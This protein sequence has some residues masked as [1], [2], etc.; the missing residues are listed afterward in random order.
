MAGAAPSEFYWVAADNVQVP[1]TL[2]DLKG[3][4]LAMLARGCAAFL[5][6]P[7]L[8]AQINA[9]TTLAA[10]QAIVWP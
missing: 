4:Y 7:T 8:K 3:L 2:P 6:L 9:A 10:V 1:F 5:Q